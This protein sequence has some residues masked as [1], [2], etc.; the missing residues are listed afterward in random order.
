MNPNKLAAKTPENP[1]AEPTSET[2]A[3][4]SPR[5]PGRLRQVGR[6]VT[7]RFVRFRDARHEKRQAKKEAAAE[8]DFIEANK[9]N[10]AF[11]RDPRFAEF[12]DQ[13]L[14]KRQNYFGDDYD[15]S[16]LGI[17]PNIAARNREL[18]TFREQARSGRFDETNIPKGMSSDEKLDLWHAS[19]TAQLGPEAVR[20]NEF[21][22]LLRE[23]HR[24]R[25]TQTAKDEAARGVIRHAN[26]LV[27]VTRRF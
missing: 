5:S 9:E 12:W 10:P 2:S 21:D 26:G 23:A 1:F 25:A 24:A 11:A 19:N 22:Q 6:K 14:M 4:E 17:N 13:D 27:Q 8:A 15:E 16:S 18:K 3:E 20:Q 7:G